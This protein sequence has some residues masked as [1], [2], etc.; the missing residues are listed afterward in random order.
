MPTR[1]WMI[2]RH[3]TL[4]RVAWLV[5]AALFLAAVALRTCAGSA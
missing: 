5:G 1:W 4:V 2:A 3:V